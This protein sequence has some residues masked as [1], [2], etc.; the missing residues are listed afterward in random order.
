MNYASYP[1]KAYRYVRDAFDKI[2][3]CEKSL[4]NWT[5]P[6]NADPGLTEASFQYLEKTISENEQKGKKLLFALSMD[7]MKIMRHQYDIRFH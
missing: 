5:S 1:L 4:A 6:L 7:E 2:L 3:P